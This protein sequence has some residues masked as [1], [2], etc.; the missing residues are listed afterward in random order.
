[1]HELGLT[2][3][4][5]GLVERE[6]KNHGFDRAVEIRLG[7]GEYSGIMAECLMDFFPTAAKGTA[8][9]G[10]ELVIVPLEGSFRCPECGYEGKVRRSEACCPVCGSTAIRM[11]AGREF[12]VESLKVE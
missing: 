8:C 3:S 6:K 1:M 7:I 4:I 11:I 9:E 12:Y 5:I 2:Q 10:A